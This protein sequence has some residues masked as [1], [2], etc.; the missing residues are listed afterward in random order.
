MRLINSERATFFDKED[1]RHQ[2]KIH[3]IA[4]KLGKLAFELEKILD[5]AQ[6]KELGDVQVKELEGL[7][8]TQ[9]RKQGEPETIS[10]R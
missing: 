6:V 5:S 7:S 2:L 9:L 1:Q 8:R 4:D 3:R 10:K